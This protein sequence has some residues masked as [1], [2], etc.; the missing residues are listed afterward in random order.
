MSRLRSVM[1]A[2][3][4]LACLWFSGT[5][6]ANDLFAPLAQ[7]FAHDHYAAPRE[8]L[9]LRKV[10]LLMRHGV[11]PP[12]STPKFQAYASEPLPTAAQWGAPDGNLTPNGAARVTT[13]G[14]FER[15]LYAVQGLLPPTG[16][17]AA[18]DLFVWADNADE[19][20]QATGLALLQGLYPG[21]TYPK[22]YSS[23]AAADLLFSPNF[24]LDTTAA[25]AAVLERMGGSFAALQAKLAPVIADMGTVLGCC[26]VTLCQQLLKTPTCTFPQLPSSFTVGAN[27]LS[28]N[29]PLATGSSIAQIFQLE[30]MNGFTGNDVAFGNASTPA[31]IRYLMSLYTNKY[32]Y[33]DRT[34]ILART[35]GSDI[36]T[37]ILYAVY[38][39]TGTEVPGGPPDG[40]LTVFV[41]HDSTISAVG[42]MLNLDWTLRSY[43]KDDMPAGGAL[44][45]ELLSLK[46]G[47][48]ELYYVRPIYLTA[49][50]QQ[51]HGDATLDA[52]NPPI[53]ESLRLKGCGLDGGRLCTLDEFVSIVGTAIDTNA[54]APESYQ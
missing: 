38:S 23:A 32:Y 50:L 7:D 29:G 45:F 33:F 41:G 53:Y 46:V 2:A 36:A 25:Q 39:G 19:R 16:C 14:A 8:G 17:P 42:G 31:A 30:Y 18:G 22:Y 27:S 34:P 47:K 28:L 5:A 10:V 3:L 6:R 1:L 24:P 43:Q 11:R 52:D 20:T 12:T 4:A 13:F 40:K 49:T 44:G 15:K 35:N 54:I 9:V 37:Q 21:C 26:S 48:N 51:I